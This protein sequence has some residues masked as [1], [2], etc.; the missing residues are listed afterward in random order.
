MLK[1]QRFREALEQPFSAAQNDRRDENGQLVNQAGI[2][3]LT[4]DIG[5]AHDLH[6]L[7][8]GGLLGTYD[9]FWH[10]SDDA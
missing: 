3:C 7:V 4:D 9:C 2:E 10:A 6:I 5:P 8:A 1:V